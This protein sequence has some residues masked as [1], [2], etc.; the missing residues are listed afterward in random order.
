M[1]SA[2]TAIYLDDEL[3]A[4]FCKTCDIAEHHLSK[5]VTANQRRGWAAGIVKSQ[6][7]DLLYR[8]DKT[9]VPLPKGSNVKAKRNKNGSWS[10]YNEG[11]KVYSGHFGYI[12][13]GKNH[14]ADVRAGRPK[15][16]SQSPNISYRAYAWVRKNPKTW[17]SCASYFESINAIMK[18][19]MPLH[20]KSQ[21][22]IANTCPVT[23]GNSV[24]TTGAVNRNFQTACHLDGDYS[25]SFSSLT[26]HG[27][28]HGGEFLLPQLKLAINV[29]PRDVLFCRTNILWHCNAPILSGVRTSVVCYLRG[30][31]VGA[32]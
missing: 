29:R 7:G 25:G 20:W 31:L 27:T 4:K 8:Y 1:I 30:K 10:P 2:S 32:Q 19:A 21:Q 5:A 18:E 16:S 14:R 22:L 13:A 17:Q 12:E 11:N 15:F 26:T 24:W 9:Y 28:F 3:V 6:P 23:M